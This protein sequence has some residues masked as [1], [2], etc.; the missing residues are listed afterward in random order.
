MQF[1]LTLSGDIERKQVVYHCE[2]RDELLQVEYV[3]APPN[4]L[5]ILAVDDGEPL[6]FASVISASGVRYASGF[7]IWWTKGAEASLYD[8][9]A[10]D[11]DTAIL[12]CLEFN[13]IP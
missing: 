2:G 8:L 7:H 10:D 9:L 3:I 5:A 12:S 6:V 4:F 13:D 1:V 11:P